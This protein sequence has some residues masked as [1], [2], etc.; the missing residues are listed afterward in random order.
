MQ[1]LK[2]WCQGPAFVNQVSVE[3]GCVAA[4][5]N[6]PEVSDFFKAREENNITV[7]F[8]RMGSKAMALLSSNVRMCRWATFT[9]VEVH[10]YLSPPPTLAFVSID[11]N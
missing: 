7:A 1:M 3:I 10:L 4:G 11:R 2:N 8:L 5:S 9:R 6:L